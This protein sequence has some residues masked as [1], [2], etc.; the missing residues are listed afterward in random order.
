M[1]VDNG[2]AR[3]RLERCWTG[4][5][6]VRN[7]NLW[8]MT[9]K[10]DIRPEVVRK[11]WVLTVEWRRRQCRE[12]K[13]QVQAWGGGGRRAKDWLLG[14]ATTSP[15]SPSLTHSATAPSTPTIDR[16]SNSADWALALD[17]PP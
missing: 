12:K 15:P 1:A 16:I 5:N 2:T 3:N 11:S 17:L 14:H 8:G 13:G 6:F 10:K 7:Q 9:F 4:G